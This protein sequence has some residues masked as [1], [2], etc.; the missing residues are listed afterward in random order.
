MKGLLL[1]KGCGGETHIVRT[2][3]TFRSDIVCETF[4]EKK[5][6]SWEDSSAEFM[7]GS[8]GP[9]SGLCEVCVEEFGD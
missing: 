1:V 2:Y 9:D 6:S 3:E 5:F 7:V 8:V 4:C